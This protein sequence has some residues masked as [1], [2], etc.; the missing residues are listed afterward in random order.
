[1]HLFPGLGVL[2][3]SAHSTPTSYRTTEEPL[4]Y[5][6][7]RSLPEMMEIFH[8]HAALHSGYSLCFLGD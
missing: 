8:V 2:L 1:M 5:N 6:C 4:E 7:L 3:L